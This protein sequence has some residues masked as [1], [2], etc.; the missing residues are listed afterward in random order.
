MKTNSISL[1]LAG[2]LFGACAG[3][4]NQVQTDGVVLAVRTVETGETTEVALLSGN[5][6][7]PEAAQVA[8]ESADWIPMDQ[9]AQDDELDFIDASSEGLISDANNQIEFSR[10]N[11]NMNNGHRNN[12]HSGRR[13]NNHHRG[14]NWRPHHSNRHWQSHTWHRPTNHY[15][16]FN[17]CH[18]TFI[19]HGGRCVVPRSRVWG[20]YH[21][22]PRHGFI[23]RPHRGHVRYSNSS[24]FVR[25]YF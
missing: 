23:Y 20:N 3:D 7:T 2:L 19:W 13:S 16:N 17:R 15:W 4:K 21:W 14:N 25:L 12:R 1:I 11:R 24:W 18:H 10:N 6:D 9:F 22:R 8:V 5:F